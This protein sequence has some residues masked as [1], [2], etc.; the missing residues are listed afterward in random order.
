MKTSSAFICFCFLFLWFKETVAQTSLEPANRVV[1]TSIRN[2]FYVDK[3]YPEYYQNYLNS[4]INFG[5]SSAYENSNT[6]LV[7]DQFLMN[8]PQSVCSVYDRSICS[9]SNAFYKGK[10]PNIV[11]TFYYKP[12]SDFLVQ[13][14]I[15]TGFS[16]EK[17]DISPSLM[18]GAGYRMYT[19]DAK[20]SQIIV[21]GTTWIGTKVKHSPCYDTY[22]RQYY[23]A[24]LSAF[25]DYSYDQTPASYTLKVW[26]QSFF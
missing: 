11:S 10:Y 6:A 26:F 12:T 2:L 4:Q 3:L 21:E 9:D 18:L 7:N 5:I 15:N 17:L 19:S 24:N 22:D 14:G 1:S 23:C 13:F 20:L 25:S 8:L 16:S